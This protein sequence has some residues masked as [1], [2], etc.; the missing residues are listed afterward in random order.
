ASD[1]GGAAAFIIQATAANA[2]GCLTLTFNSDGTDE[3]AGWSAD[4]NCIP[5][6][7]IIEAVL[8]STAPAVMPAD[9]GWIDICP[10]DRVFFWGKGN[11]P[12]NGD[13]YNHSDLTSDF[14]WDFGDG[15]FT[16]GPNVSHVF[17]EPGGYVVQLAITDQLGCKNTNFISQRIRVAPRPHFALGDYPTQI[18]SGDT[19]HL[20][21]MVNNLDSMHTVSVMAAE[22]GFQTLGVRSDS[23]PLPD[24]NGS[25]YQTTINFTDF[26]PGQILTNLGD[27]AGIFVNMEHSWMRDLQIR[28]TCPN[29]QTAIL[30]DHPGQTGGE[31]FLGIPYEAD[32]GFSTPVPGVGYDYGWA[33]N[34]DFNYTWIEYANAFLPTTLPTGTY[35]SYEPLNNFLGCPL[36]GEWTIE[37]T[38]LWAIDNGYIFSWAIEF[39]PDIY[40]NIETFSAALDSWSWNNHPSIFSSTPDSISGSPV[41]AGEVAYTFR[42]N[43]EFGCAWDTTVDIQ[44]LPYTHPACHSCTEILMPVPDTTVCFEESVMMDAGGTGLGDMPVT[45]ESYDDYAIGAGNHPP[46]N[47]Y[48]SAIQVNSINP[49][50]ISDV[51][52]DISSI[53][54]DLET[55]FDA[56]IQLYLEAPNGQLLELSTGNGGSGDNYTQTCFTPVA[57]MPIAV[58]SPP[59]TGSF[60]PEGNWTA[61]NGAPVNGNWSLRVSDSFGLN[62]FGNLNWWS[63]TFNS[64]NDITYT[65]SPPAGLSCIDCP[66]PSAT[67]SSD[68]SYVVSASDSYGCTSTDTVQINILLSFPAPTVTCQQQPGGEILV[69]WN[70]VTSG[71]PGYLVNV[72]NGGWQTPNNGNLSHI[73][74]GLVNGD[75]VDIQVEVDAGAAACQVDVG[76]SSCTYLLCPITASVLTPGPYAVTCA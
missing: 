48:S 4:I 73:V 34:P 31:V 11:Y 75:A 47:P 74:S 59:F 54:L 65:W 38:D 27:L 76:T 44:V 26:S 10:G 63:I 39:N 52:T 53:C 22:E 56:D 70:D 51:F 66:N 25:S 62:T 46:A 17:D 42:V 6:C 24:G 72:N 15:N 8:D 61:L 50:V 20:N 18:C 28:L 16:F 41:N 35:N 67:P 37:V 60:A 19:V 69:T 71:S 40:P 43:D 36:N 58:G 33:P 49:A 7:Q 23:L 68:V 5:A 32:E 3:A 12:Q 55:D 29:G 30:H 21:A 9:T 45:F 14:E 64:V 13:V 57:T 1:F 2:S